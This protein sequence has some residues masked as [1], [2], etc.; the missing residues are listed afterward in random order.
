[1]ESTIAVGP[2]R[3]YRAP[4]SVAF[5]NCASAL[6][7]ILPK[8]QVW[9]VDGDSKFV[10]QV[11]KPQYWRI[12][13]SNKSDEEKAK[14]DELKKILDDV[15]LFEKTPCPFQR[16]FEVILPEPPSTPVTKRPWK[17][18]QGPRPRTPL[19]QEGDVDF[20]YGSPAFTKRASSASPLRHSLLSNRRRNSELDLGSRFESDSTQNQESNSS[21]P[22]NEVNNSIP[23]I[24]ESVSSQDPEISGMK[25]LLANQSPDVSV[26]EQSIEQDFD[27]NNH[28][29]DVRADGNSRDDTGDESEA[30]DDTPR[31]RGRLSQLIQSLPKELDKDE[32]QKS[33]P[34]PKSPEAPPVL[35]IM[36]TPSAQVHITSPLHSAVSDTESLSSGIESWHSLSP[37]TS[38]PSSPKHRFSHLSDNPLLS[39]NPEASEL[40]IAPNE[41]RTWEVNT[42]P[43]VE[44][45]RSVVSTSPEPHTP[46]LTH[47]GSERSDD[48]RFEI[49]TPPSIR[50]G[51][52]HRAT[53]SSN[54]RRR[55]L[56]PLPAAVNLFSPTRT[57]PRHLQTAR[58]L[59]TAIIQKTYE[60]LLSPPSHLFHM[61]LN[62]ASKIAAGEWRGVLLGHGEAVH[63]DLEDE[64]AGQSWHEDDYGVGLHPQAKNPRSQ[65]SH[66]EV[67]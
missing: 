67:D 26:G 33:P 53:T 15:L 20:G 63:W 43:D 36:T 41:S 44:I 4:G 60:I 14:V 24:D 48:D 59:P 21:T 18:V 64:Y 17:P 25:G 34:S 16:D 2:L 49:M 42:T 39:R 40:S 12:E 29:V 65:P 31:P 58:H 23:E 50:P 62:I 37:T 27:I 56:S 32:S 1:M 38:Q 10:L 66:W 22:P 11:R 3:I 5:L 9:C 46:T 28:E 54:S 6:R 30:T 13:V 8:S 19:A 57:R 47:D 7:P 61:M 52:R 55:Q 35:T 51:V 45:D